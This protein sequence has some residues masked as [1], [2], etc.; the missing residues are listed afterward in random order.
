M[1]VRNIVV[2]I[3]LDDETTKYL[4]GGGFIDRPEKL[5]FLAPYITTYGDQDGERCKK[6]NFFVLKY[7]DGGDPRKTTR[8]AYTVFPRSGH[9]SLTGLR[10]ESEVDKAVRK[11]ARILR[12]PRGAKRAAEWERKVVNCTYVCKLKY[13]ES[14]LANN[15][16]EVL[17]FHV[18]RVEEVNEFCCDQEGYY[19]NIRFRSQFFPGVRITW[20]KCNLDKCSRKSERVHN[21]LKREKVPGTALI[22]NTGNVVILGVHNEKEAL[23]LRDKICA[24]IKG[25]V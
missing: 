7:P 12:I 14:D 13:A 11:L 3:K 21:G 15:P 20:D 19:P 22:F 18:K 8:W 6:L 25:Q 10:C 16:S 4:S 17:N 9:V 24:L 2:H 5:S 1:D 23:F